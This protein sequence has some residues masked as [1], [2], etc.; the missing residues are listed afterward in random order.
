[1][2][3][4]WCS[5]VRPTEEHPAPLIRSVRS[6]GAGREVIRVDPVAG[7][8]LRRAVLFMRSVGRRPSLTA[9]DAASA[10]IDQWCDAVADEYLGGDEFRPMGECWPCSV[11]MT[12]RIHG[13]SALANCP[14][15][16]V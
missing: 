5:Q 14:Q 3:R 2:A 13:S 4:Q 6:L 11:M 8:R 10:A 16:L 1:L 12:I 7:E 9:K 15:L